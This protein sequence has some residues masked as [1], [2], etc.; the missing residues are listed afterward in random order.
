MTQVEEAKE[1]ESQESEWLAWVRSAGTQAQTQGFYFKFRALSLSS[2]LEQ[3]NGLNYSDTVEAL[4]LQ[5]AVLDMSLSERSL[6]SNEVR[7][8]VSS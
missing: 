3:H 6:T 2:C 8:Q 5:M 7:T 4:L 1:T